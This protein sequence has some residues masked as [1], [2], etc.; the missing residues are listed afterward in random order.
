MNRFILLL[1]LLAGGTTTT[2]AQKNKKQTN[3]AAAAT[4]NREWKP[5]KGDTRNPFDTVKT[6]QFKTAK[7]RVG[8]KTSEANTGNSAKAV[9]RK[10]KKADGY[11]SLD[12]LK[13][14]PVMVNGHPTCPF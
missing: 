11:Y 7:N 14:K 6:K 8:R 2:F 13:V 4:E 10:E 12:S 5:G 1:L 9:S 3:R